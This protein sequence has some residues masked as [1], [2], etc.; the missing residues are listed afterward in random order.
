[1]APLCFTQ[2]L[3]HFTV[4]PQVETTTTGYVPD[5][6]ATCA[7]TSSSLST[8][9]AAPAAR[10]WASGAGPTASLHFASTCGS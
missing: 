6:Q 9:A 8:G 1:M 3:A 10:D 7:K 2:Q 4:L 5:D